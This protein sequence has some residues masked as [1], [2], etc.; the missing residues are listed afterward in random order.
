MSQEYDFYPMKPKSILRSSQYEVVPTSH[1]T[2]AVWQDCL[3]DAPLPASPSNMA[4]RVRVVWAEFRQ[5]ELKGYQYPLFRGITIAGTPCHNWSVHLHQTVWTNQM[6]Y[7]QRAFREQ[8]ITEAPRFDWFWFAQTHASVGLLS[9][10]PPLVPA[11][12]IQYGYTQ[13]QYLA[14]L[15]QCWDCVHADYA[16]PWE[17]SRF[18]QDP[19]SLARVRMIGRVAREEIDHT[20]HHSHTYYLR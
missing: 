20:A 13:Q 2:Y 6:Y 7:A 18:G 15:E 5:G 12:L 3:R 9:W 17:D 8:R 1:S 4:E 16:I 14:D 10:Y 19:A 11:W